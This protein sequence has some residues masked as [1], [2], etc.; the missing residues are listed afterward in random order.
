MDTGYQ[1]EA[2]R[3]SGQGAARCRWSGL[4]L[5]ANWTPRPTGRVLAWSRLSTTT[6]RSASAG[7]TP[8]RFVTGWAEK[9]E[10]D[11]RPAHRSPRGSMPAAPVPKRG[12]IFRDDEEVAQ[13][14][15]P[16]K[17]WE[18][19]MEDAPGFRHGSSPTPGAC[20][21]CTANIWEWTADWYAD[22]YYQ[23]S[24]RGGIR[25]APASAPRD[26]AWRRRFYQLGR[27]PLR[28]SQAASN[29]R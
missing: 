10:Q 7:T 12:S 26:D 29:P 24:P 23:K 11:L 27:C 3:K 4:Q 15:H 1:T 2:T 13:Y 17:M 9:E 20:M 21:T 5:P 28:V 22:D 6:R 19:V 25:P 18:P 8:R 16:G 14:V